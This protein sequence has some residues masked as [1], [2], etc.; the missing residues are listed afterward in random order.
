MDL[1]LKGK[2]VLITGASKGIGLA[3]AKAFAAEGANLHLAARSVDLLA[4]A[5]SEIKARHGVGVNVETHVCDLRAE[6]AVKRLADDCA[7][8]DILVNNAGD[9]PG[10]S[11]ETVDDA[12]WR[13]A[14][15]LKVFGYINLTR[16]MLAHMKP[17]GKGVIVNVV[18]MAGVTHPPEY[19]CG[20]M[21]NAALEAFTKGV[22]KGSIEYGVRVLGM[23][24]PATR[25]DRIIQLNKTIAKNK[26]GDE[27]RWEELL[28]QTRMIE[29]EQVADTVLYFASERANHLSG[30]MLN[31][32]SY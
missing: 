11:I 8:V 10:G 30:V 29:P 9:I 27:S 2:S 24:P 7:K 23:H 12:R 32:G 5:A 18:G 3:C 17:R 13:H 21:G 26:F 28:K 15:E 19:I 1:G 25:T 14:W 20:T 16:A 22:G 31:L 6:G 4:A